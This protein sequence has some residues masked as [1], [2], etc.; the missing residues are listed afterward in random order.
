MPS[1]STW[2]RQK[3]PGGAFPAEKAAYSAANNLPYV[4]YKISFSIAVT[5]HSLM[6]KGH[7]NPAQQRCYSFATVKL[8]VAMDSSRADEVG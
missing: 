2:A 6:E 4:V 1:I 8:Y 5:S 7:N 3:L